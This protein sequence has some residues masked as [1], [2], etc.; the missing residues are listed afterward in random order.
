M[1]SSWRSLTEVPRLDLRAEMR[2]EPHHRRFLNW[3]PVVMVLFSFL[4]LL[5]VPLWVAG[6]INRYREEI[7]AYADPAHALVDSIN[8]EL[9]IEGFSIRGYLVN[10]DPVFLRKYAAARET[11]RRA[12]DSLQPYVQRIG[13]ETVP[14]YETL[15][16][17]ISRWHA[18]QDRL[19]AHHLTD[20]TAHIAAMPASQLFYEQAFAASEVLA[21]QISLFEESRRRLIRRTDDL[22]GTATVWLTIVGILATFGA[23]WLALRLS[24]LAMQLERRA[25][26]EMAFRQIA[27]TLTGAVEID[28]VLL[29][30]TQSAALV[31][32]A[33]GAYVEKMMPD[34]TVE[35]LAVSGRGTPKRGMTARYPGSLTAEI[36][37]SGQPVIVADSR[38]ASEPEMAPYLAEVCTDCEVMIVP[39]LAEKEA[40]GALVL[41]NSKTSGRHFGTS[42]ARGAKSLGDLVS[43]ALRRVTMMARERE[44]REEAQAALATRDDVLGIVSHDLRNP[45]TSILLSAS[46]LEEEAEGDVKEQIQIIKVA[47]QRMQRLIRDLLDVARMEGGRLTLKLQPIDSREVAMRACDEHRAIA[48]Q[49]SQTIVCEVPPGLPPICGDHDRILQ[50]FGNLL[51]NAVK[52]T[53]D[54]GHI[55]VGARRNGSVVEYSVKDSGPGIPERD[56]AH[57]FERYWQAKKTAHLGAGLGLAIARGI[58]ESHGGSVSVANSAD[59]GAIFSFAIPIAGV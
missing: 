26:E 5:V 30:I 34:S 51:G 11:E 29:E 49:R 42:D 46:L 16:E 33:D 32:R 28:E 55:T 43:L 6:R 12:L 52:F 38:R 13:R 59:G 20:R 22:E 39:L 40:L 58:A 8:L 37:D 41:L 17:S 53:P 35:V 57:V 9:A 48:S 31:T 15:R 44:A 1:S 45:L 4:T 18:L 47:A 7:N 23:G 27:S 2:T 56:L 3:F 19:L 10:D 14:A 50:L 25:R 21:K 54:G 36:I 24:S